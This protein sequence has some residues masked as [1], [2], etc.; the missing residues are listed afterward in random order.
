MTSSKC[1][2]NSENSS[3]PKTVPFGAPMSHLRV[4]EVAA[5]DFDDVRLDPTCS[6]RPFDAESVLDYPPSI[7]IALTLMS[8]NV[9]VITTNIILLNITTNIV[10]L[11]VLMKA[12]AITN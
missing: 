6:R 3:G 2:V 1:V 5:D 11:S 9:Y 4:V 10:L 8:H 12:M 7:E